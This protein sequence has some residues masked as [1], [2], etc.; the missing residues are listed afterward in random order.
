[1]DLFSRPCSPYVDPTPTDRSKEHAMRKFTFRSTRRSSDNVDLA[2]IG[3]AVAEHGPDATRRPLA[4]VH[5]Q[6]KVLGVSPAVV[7]LLIDPTV[8][9]VVVARA[10]AHVSADMGRHAADRSRWAA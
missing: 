10:L 8:P 5:R 7:D 3:E 4:Q 6:A 9:D 2:A 1:L